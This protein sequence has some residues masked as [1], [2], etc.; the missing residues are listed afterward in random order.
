ML[1]QEWSWREEGRKQADES[2]LHV[3]KEGVTGERKQREPQEILIN[4]N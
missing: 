2:E 1:S 4:N 3:V